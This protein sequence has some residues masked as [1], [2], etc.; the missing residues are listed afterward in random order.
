MK[1]TSGSDDYGNNGGCDDDD[2]G[3]RD[4]DER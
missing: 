4:S 1:K 3:D 2:S